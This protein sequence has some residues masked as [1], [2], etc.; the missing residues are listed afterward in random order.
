MTIPCRRSRLQATSSL[1]IKYHQ[2]RMNIFVNFYFESNKKDSN[3]SNIPRNIQQTNKV[4]FVPLKW[5]LRLH[6]RHCE[7]VFLLICLPY[8]SWKER[9]EI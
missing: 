3:S 9:R 2:L 6:R 7:K 1:L 8:P 5:R 4:P